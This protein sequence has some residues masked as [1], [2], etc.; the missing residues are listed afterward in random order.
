M[1]K[2]LFSDIVAFEPKTKYY[3]KEYLF[4]EATEKRAGYLMRIA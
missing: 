2:A 4:V 1:I 3:N